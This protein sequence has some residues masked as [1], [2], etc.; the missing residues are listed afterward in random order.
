MFPKLSRL[1]D[2]QQTAQIAVEWKGYIT[3]KID[4]D[5][6]SA[7]LYWQFSPSFRSCCK[8]QPS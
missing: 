4:W 7:N 6:R 8:W 2:D 1:S 3:A 5:F